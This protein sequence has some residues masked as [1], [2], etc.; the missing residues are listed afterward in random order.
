MNPVESRLITGTVGELLVQLRLFQYGV[1]AAPPLIDTGNDL[2]AVRGSTFKA[3]QVKTTGMENGKWEIPRERNYHILALVRLCG[4]NSELLLD[5]AE[6]YLLSR[7]SI[8]TKKCNLND[9]QEYR[10]SQAV[11]DRLIPSLK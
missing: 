6:I 2:I 4:E 3:I 5:K 11:V 1:Q 8:N 9:L 7:D 10:I